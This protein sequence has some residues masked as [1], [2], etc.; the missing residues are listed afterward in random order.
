MITAA[1]RRAGG[2]DTPIR[3]EIGSAYELPFQDASFD[4]TRAERVFMHLAQP[5]RALHE[6]R[7]VTHT[8]GRVC[9]VD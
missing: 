2:L 7:R 3:F 4:A 5:E 6:M 9:V 8:G 1:R